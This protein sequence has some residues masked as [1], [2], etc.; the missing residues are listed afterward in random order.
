[1]EK[2]GSFELCTRKHII[3]FLHFGKNFQRW[4]HTVVI[5]THGIVKKTSK[6]PQSEIDK[7]E[8]IRKKYFEQKSKR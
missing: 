7:V 5:S 2:Y 3:G 4:T 8:R 6:V 1:M